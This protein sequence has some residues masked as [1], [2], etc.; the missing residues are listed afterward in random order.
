MATLSK[1]RKKHYRTGWAARCGNSKGGT[2]QGCTTGHGTHGFL[3]AQFLPLWAPTSKPMPK[4]DELERDFFTS[5]SF[6]SDLY[7]FQ[8]MDVSSYAYPYNILLAHHDAERHIRK[9]NYALDLHIVHDDTGKAF[10]ATREVCYTSRL[11]YYIPVLPVHRMHQA[12]ETSN[13]AEIL[14]P[15]LTYLCKIAGIPYYRDEGCYM[16]YEYEMV[17]DWIMDCREEWDEQNYKIIQKEIKD[18][19]RLG[20][21]MGKILYD[22]KQLEN[23]HGNLLSFKPV[24]ESD[25]QCLYLSETAYRLYRAYPER[26]LFSNMEEQTTNQ[27]G[28]HE[29]ISPEQYISFIADHKGL[30]LEQ[31][32]ESVNCH[33]QELYGMQE[34]VMIQTF[35]CKQDQKAGNLQFEGRM[36]ALLTN[37]N[38]FLQQ[39]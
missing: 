35:E 1:D 22:K 34:P 15:V 14:F 18:A 17:K 30:L 8:P 7:G 5:L 31:V 21:K 24:T 4:Q 16:Y 29:L 11:L 9:E 23:W 37:L 27:Y 36:F 25:Y 13:A 2:E 26:H 33:L 6:L 3:R 20:D 28:E 38:A 32:S 12:K 10:L 19:K 39:Y